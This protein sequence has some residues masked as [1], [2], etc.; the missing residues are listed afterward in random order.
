MMPAPSAANAASMPT[1]VRVDRT[2][3]A[4]DALA[5]VGREEAPLVARRRE[6]VGQASV[7]REILGHARRSVAREVRG[8]AQHTIA[9]VPI[10]ARRAAGS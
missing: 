7:L 6:L 4:H 2:A 9:V 10:R 8:D 5:A 3:D 1:V